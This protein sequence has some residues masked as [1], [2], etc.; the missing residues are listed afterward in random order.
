MLRFL[1]PV[2]GSDNSGSAIEKFIKLLGWYKELPEIHLLNVQ[3]PQR[4]NV[5]LLIDKESIEIYHR[6]EGM[7]ALKAARASLDH[8]NIAYQHHIA[9]GSPAETITRYAMEIDCDQIVIGPRGLG[10]MKGILLGSVAA[11]VMHLSTIP[12]LLIK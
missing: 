3:L 4:G 1:V 9:V 2:D 8:N 6:E 11:Q 7:K 12:V 10:I 5:P